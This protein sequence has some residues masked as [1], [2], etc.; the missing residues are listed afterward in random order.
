MHGAAGLTVTEKTQVATVLFDAS[1]AVQFTAVVPTG[2]LDPDGGVQV[3]VTL[4]QPLAVGNEKV[5]VAEF[6]PAGLSVAN[7]SSG[8][9]RTQTRLFTCTVKLHDSVLLELFVV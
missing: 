1:F 8:Q 6:E 9:R 7:A 2:K 4:G 3:L 5:T